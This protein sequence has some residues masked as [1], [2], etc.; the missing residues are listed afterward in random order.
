MRLSWSA[1]VAVALLGAGAAAAQYVEGYLRLDDEY[2]GANSAACVAYDSVAN[3][4]YVSGWRATIVFDAATGRKLARMPQYGDWVAAAPADGKMYVLGRSLYSFDAST[5]QLIGTVEV[6]SRTWE[7]TPPAAVSSTLHKLYHCTEYSVIGVVDTRT[8]SLLRT[9]ALPGTISGLCYAQNLEKLYV[10]GWR[11]ITVIDCISDSIIAVLPV[12]TDRYWVQA[13]SPVSEKLYHGGDYLTVIDCRADTVLRREPL[14]YFVAFMAYDP[15]SNRVYCDY[16][17]RAVLT[18]DCA[19][20]SVVRVV[21]TRTAETWYASFLN[22]SAGK[23]YYDAG[24]NRATIWVYDCAA[25]SQVAVLHGALQGFGP[26]YPNLCL[27]PRDNI[28]YM[29]NYECGMVTVIDGAGDSLL[30]TVVV[31]DNFGLDELWCDWTTGRVYGLAEHLGA[32]SVIDGATN[33]L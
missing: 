10:T 19:S 4:V 29:A 31:G 32:L 9:I 24:C 30:R 22:S 14:P 17:E 27:N 26:P 16:G 18:I 7:I 12:W 5:H 21:E 15:L 11:E 13:Y 6:R 3:A 20:D 23:F 8:D 25:D 2:S 33:T 1:I 28:V